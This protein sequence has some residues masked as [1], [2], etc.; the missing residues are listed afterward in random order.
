MEKEKRVPAVES[1]AHR[2][3]KKNFEREESGSSVT[4]IYLLCIH[5]MIQIG[6]VFLL[7]IFP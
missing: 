2:L 7:L 5:L 4:H 3:V 6:K 1:E